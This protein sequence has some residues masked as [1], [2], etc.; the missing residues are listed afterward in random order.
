MQGY[1]RTGKSGGREIMFRGAYIEWKGLKLPLKLSPD[2]AYE[3]DMLQRRVKLV[4]LVRRPGKRRDRWYAQLVL[5]GKP[6]IKAD[7]V[8]GKA[9]HP[10]GSGPVGL[11][12][13]PQTLAYSAAGAA[14]LVELADRVQNI[15]QEKRRLQR[16]MDR[17]RR[18]A[19]P[20]NY[21]EDGTIRRG[22]KLTHNKSKRYRRNQQELKYL[23]HRQAE[24]RKLQHIQLANH[25]LS[26]GDHFYVEKMEWSSLTHRAKK[27]VIS[28]K[29][30]KPRSKK[31]FGK[32]IAN[33]APAML[34]EILRQKCKSLGLPNVVEINPADIKASQY[35]HLTG[36]YV[37]KSLSRR[38][39]KQKTI[40]LELLRWLCAGLAVV[41]LV[42]SFRQEPVSS[43]A[44]EDVASAVTAS[45][46]LSALQEGS[47]Q[48]VKRL[49][50]LNPSD[51]DGCLLY[52][53]QTNME[54]EELLLLKLRDTSQQEAVRAAVEARLETQKT[55]F[56]GYGLEQY[57]LLTNH[58]ILDIRGNYVLF[59]VHK[60]AAAVQQAFRGA[61]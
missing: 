54:A 12:I 15:E 34:I 56:D 42:V 46:D 55:S 25:L 2:N 40:L 16:K 60:D 44:F 6:A 11:D 19:N 35:N 27:T 57:D 22:V 3:T 9:V 49:Y 53:P 38:Q 43:A 41:F 36:E 21:A 37:K 39:M 4:R 48:M 51:F 24:I 33:K 59:I 1:S 5:E 7:P 8:T 58:S 14:G 18:A 47:V 29:T 10:I 30:G 31:R 23:Q 20:D 52:Y 32:S 17:S 45:V 28:E 61:L 13:G 26:L 50:G